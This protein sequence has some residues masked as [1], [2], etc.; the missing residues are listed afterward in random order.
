MV[1][2]TVCLR[3]CFVQDTDGSALRP[4][5]RYLRHP[6]GRHAGV[7]APGCSKDVVRRWVSS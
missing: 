4:H 5:L 3:V 6:D 7:L 2:C 1:T